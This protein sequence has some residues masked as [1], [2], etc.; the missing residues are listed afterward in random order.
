MSFVH[1]SET[2]GGLSGS[3]RRMTIARHSISTDAAQYTV[4]QPNAAPKTPLNVRA[5]SAPTSSPPSTVPT[6][7]PRWSSG[8]WWAAN[9]T[10]TWTVDAV[11]PTAK[12]ATHSHRTFGDIAVN[13]SAMD[14]AT[15]SVV[16]NLR[17]SYLSPS[18]TDTSMS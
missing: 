17:R 16:I 8:A 1:Q 10:I 11:A 7:R 15:R 14:A 12:P 9:G 18:G 2:V 4:R 3:V 5:R 6:I 13:A